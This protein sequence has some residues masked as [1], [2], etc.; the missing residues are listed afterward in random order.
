MAVSFGRLSR[1][2][3]GT[4]PEKWS[5]QPKIRGYFEPTLPG[6][7]FKR[8]FACQFYKESYFADMLTTLYRVLVAGAFVFSASL[9]AARAQ[10]P[11]TDYRSEWAEALSRL[12][13]DQKTRLLEYFHQKPDTNADDRLNAIFLTLPSDRRRQA[14][15]Y[16]AFLGRPP[17]VSEALA[18][19]RWEKD[20]LY[21]GQLEEG[22]AVID[23]FGVTNIGTTPYVIKEIRTACDCTV[24]R[25][26]ER[27]VAPGETVYIRVEFDPTRKMG[28]ATP[29]FV[30]YDNSWPN[31][32]HIVYLD[33]HILPKIPPRAPRQ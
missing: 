22:V 30:V 25:Y 23:S 6:R 1:A 10:D 8:I 26:P 7:V 11:W 28:R 13:S 4:P 16:A 2:R 17:A 15:Q 32:R 18:R 3:T 29:G 33:A 14:V 24:W 19:V 12:N 20:T 5:S 9:P 21:L 31:A 27:P